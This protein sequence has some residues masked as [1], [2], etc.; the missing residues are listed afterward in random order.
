MKYKRFTAQEAIEKTDKI[1]TEMTNS[2]AYQLFVEECESNID[3]L[4][5]MVWNHYGL[6]THPYNREGIEGW[7]CVDEIIEC[8]IRNSNIHAMNVLNTD[9]I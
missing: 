3:E 1:K 5:I 9:A 4:N 8:I 7:T 2:M 6:N